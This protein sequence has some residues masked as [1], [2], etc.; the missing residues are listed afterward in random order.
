MQT[1]K[2]AKSDDQDKI[3]TR[4]F[5]IDFGVLHSCNLYPKHRRQEEEV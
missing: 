4:E 5:N 1:S 3:Q 2:R